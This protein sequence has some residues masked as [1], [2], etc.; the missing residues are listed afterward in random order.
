MLVV[1][2]DKNLAV[3]DKSAGI[4]VHPVMPTPPRCGTSSC[5]ELDRGITS[6]MKSQENTLV[7]FIINKWSEIKNFNW[8]DKTRPGVV[9]RLDK[10]TSGLIIIAKNPKTQKFLQEQFRT[11]KI[12]KTYLA[13]VLGRVEPKKGIIKTQI[14]RDQKDR[15]TQKTTFFSYSWQKQKS[16]YA[17]THYKILNYYSCFMFHVTCYMTLLELHPQTG[18]MH[19]LRIHCQH[20]GHPIIGD[21][22]YF[23]KETKKISQV[24][25]LSRQFLHAK[26]LEFILPSGKIKIVESKLPKNLLTI[27]NKLK[28]E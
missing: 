3:I 9:H 4:L 11:R 13:L 14:S 20:I 15:T 19:Q 26:K 12:Q 23:S 24:L 10:D 8:L 7:G 5:P 25:G 2:E 1:Y 6:E 21:Q 18:R 17:E 16:R 28:K 22:K 27:L